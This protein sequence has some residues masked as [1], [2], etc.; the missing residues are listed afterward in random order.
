MDHGDV[1]V[2]TNTGEKQR[3]HVFES[4][5]ETLGVPDGRIVEIQPVGHI[6]RRHEAKIG[7]QDG[8]VK[9]KDV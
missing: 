1:S 8:K 7:V 5:G 3:S 6:H 4:V 9:N 2:Q